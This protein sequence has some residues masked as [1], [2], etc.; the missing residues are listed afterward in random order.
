[1]LCAAGN[2]SS[3][4]LI[5]LS[6]NAFRSDSAVVHVLK[7]AAAGGAPLGPERA[8]PYEENRTEPFNP[9]RDTRPIDCLAARNSPSDLSKPPKRGDKM[10]PQALPFACY[11]RAS[12]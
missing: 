5:I 10:Q 9:G 1:M 2:D 7:R 6:I 4:L 11:R 12:L 3:S 8:G